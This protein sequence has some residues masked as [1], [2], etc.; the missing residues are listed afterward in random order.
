MS[1]RFERRSS[2]PSRDGRSGPGG[3]GSGRPTGGRPPSGR[4]SAGRPAMGRSGSNSRPMP[5][6]RRSDGGRSP[7][8]KSGRDGSSFRDRRAPRDEG[9]DRSRSGD[10]PGNRFGERSG[11]RSGERYGNRSGDRPRERYGDRPRSFDRDQNASRSESQND[12]SGPG[13]FQDRN[14]RY[15]DRRRSGD[16]RRQPSQRPRTRYDNGRS[17]RVNAAPEAAAATPPADD[18]IWG[19]HA[20]QAALE[21][22]RPIHRIWCTPE[23]RSAAKFL[24]LLRDAKASGVLVEEVTWARLGQITGGSVH[25]GIALQTAAAETL[26]LET[27][28]DGCSDLGEPPLLVALDSVTDPHNLGAVVRSA[29]AMG[30]HGVV[31]PQRRS[32]GLTGSAAKVAAGALEH[33][34]VARVV[35]LNRSL[36]KLK[37]AGYRVVGLAAEGDVTLTDVDLS[38]PLVLVTGSED[39]GLSLLTRRHCDQL[40]RIPLRGI[41]PSLNASV[42]TALCV[43]EVARRNWMK[44]IHGQAPSPPIRRPQL[45]G[46]ATSVET[47]E[48]PVEQAP[49]Q[50]IDLDLNPSQQ[51]AAVQFDQNIQLSP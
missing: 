5:S 35:N 1:P 11:E 43:Y 46:A 8:S 19:R 20:T 13:R 30:A 33:L 24:Q 45:A 41:T 50:R 31:I 28:I 36:E 10:R 21:A 3:S 48:A 47:S 16:E 18:L 49:E 23:M 27:L 26:D 14:D 51:D 6:N 34:P 42:A 44:D 4:P 32:A 9:W 12:R 38:G 17:P 25:Q 2:G 39:Q 29:E 7:Y 15:G 22:G 37:D 40:V